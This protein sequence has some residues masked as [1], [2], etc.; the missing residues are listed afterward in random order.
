M[1][2]YVRDNRARTEPLCRCVS[3]GGSGEP[4]GLERQQGIRE[5]R[6]FPP[7]RD[8]PFGALPPCQPRR[9]SRAAGTG[10]DGTGQDGSRTGPRPELGASAA[11]GL[12]PG[13]RDPA[14]PDGLGAGR[15][16]GS[17]GPGG[18]RAAG[19]APTGPLWQLP[20]GP[21]CLAA[22]TAP[23]CPARSCSGAISLGPSRCDFSLQSPPFF[24]PPLPPVNFCR[25]SS[26]EEVELKLLPTPC[27]ATST[28]RALCQQQEQVK[29]TSSRNK[30][31]APQK[32]VPGNEVLLRGPT[33]RGGVMQK[34]GCY[35]VTFGTE[36]VYS[37]SAR[38]SDMS[39]WSKWNILW[40]FV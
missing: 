5:I 33:A 28:W 16:R 21:G 36:R 30:N 7:P 17:P 9:G 20:A 27:S 35:K 22:V 8:E 40:Y 39:L 15:A 25:N 14:R 38:E 24:L 6:P 10:R 11:P 26:C 31:S 29:C 23:L 32:Q 12:P 13:W 1:F 4:Q 34:N 3:P 18:V 2:S 37:A 19:G